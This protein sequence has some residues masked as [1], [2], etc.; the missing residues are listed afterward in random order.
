MNKKAKAFGQREPQKNTEIKNE[1]ERRRQV[2][3]Q[4]A[5]DKTLPPPTL[6]ERLKAKLG[7]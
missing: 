4:L 7:G 2:R 3:M 6:W 1:E 5:R